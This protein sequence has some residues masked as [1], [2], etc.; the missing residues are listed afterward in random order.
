MGL[1]F[2]A[3]LT[4]LV[5]EVVNACEQRELQF[6]LGSFSLGFPCRLLL[7]QLEHA[8]LGIENA[9]R[10]WRVTHGFEGILGWPGCDVCSM[11]E[12][13]RLLRGESGIILIDSSIVPS[14]EVLLRLRALHSP[15]V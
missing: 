13:G 15:A 12:R 3:I 8:A 11:V 10:E 6:V 14:A 2:F 7:N 9:L 4:D 1:H 5:Q